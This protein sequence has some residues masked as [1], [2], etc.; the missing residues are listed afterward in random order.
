MDTEDSGDLL[1]EFKKHKTTAEQAR[2]VEDGPYN[3]FTGRELSSQYM[4]ILEKRRQLPVHMQRY[5][6]NPTFHGF[7]KLLGLVR[8]RSIAD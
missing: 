5:V 1:S 3:A 8:K 4:S 6:N 2:I 7:P